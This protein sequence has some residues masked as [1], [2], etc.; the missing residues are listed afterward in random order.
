MYEYLMKAPHILIGGTTKSGK[1]VLLN[2]IILDL[3][4]THRESETRLYLIDPKRVELYPYS[5]T[6]F[7]EY[8]TEEA[9]EVPSLLTE[10]ITEIDRRFQYMRDNSLKEYDGNSIYLIID[11]LADLMISEYV[12]P[13]R[14]GLQ[15]I[16]QIGRAANVHIIAATQAPNREVIPASLVLNFTDRIALRCLSAIESRQLINVSGAEKITG[17][18]KG[19]YMSGDGLK[20]IKIPMTS[21]EEIENACGTCDKHI[22]EPTAHIE[23]KDEG[24]IDYMKTHTPAMFKIWGWVILAF[25]PLF[26]EHPFIFLLV[27]PFCFKK[28]AAQTKYI[29]PFDK[30]WQMLKD[31]FKKKPPM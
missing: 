3:M 17:Y 18:G 10:I 14:K 25:I 11:E 26:L 2:G 15:K 7:C 29:V 13:I 22:T 12:V 1:S 9:K 30:G 19:L 16:L 6:G 4:K 28:A 21:E 31:D 8:Y 20:E 5:K 24:E 27:A 23:A